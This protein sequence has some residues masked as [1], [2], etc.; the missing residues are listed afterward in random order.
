LKGSFSDGA[1]DDAFRGKEPRL[2]NVWS[3]TS[4]RC[5]EEPASARVLLPAEEVERIELGRRA[6]GGQVLTGP[7][8]SSHGPS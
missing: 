6:P 4:S 5:P 7:S 8:S 1:R 3:S 2:D